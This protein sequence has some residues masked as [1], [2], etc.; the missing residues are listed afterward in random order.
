M[1]GVFKGLYRGHG[2]YWHGRDGYGD[3]SGAFGTLDDCHA[4]IDRL[5]AAREAADRAAFE[6]AELKGYRDGDTA[7]IEHKGR[8]VFSGS[9]R[10]ARRR[11]FA[12]CDE[13]EADIVW[14][15]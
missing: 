6:S 3:E 15:A 14:Q 13:C 9:M 8:V 4:A 12:I 2:V 11:V 1:S 7:R 10:E 5:I